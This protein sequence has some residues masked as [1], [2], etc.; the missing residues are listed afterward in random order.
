MVSYNEKGELTALVFQTI[1]GSFV[2]G[3]GCRTTVFLKG[4]PLRCKWCCNPESQQ[5]Y[6]EVKYNKEKICTG[7]GKCV[8]ICPEHA[9][10]MVPLRADESAPVK[11]GATEEKETEADS[12]CTTCLPLPSAGYQAPEITIDQ[13]YERIACFFF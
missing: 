8:E 6:P 13:D 7:C 9:I 2:D 5:I 1:H 11:E 4:C 10:T 12:A 3:Y